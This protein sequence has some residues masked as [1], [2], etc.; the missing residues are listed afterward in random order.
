M[1]K[2]RTIHDRHDPERRVAANE[3][4]QILEVV[5]RETRSLE[6]LFTASY[7]AIRRALRHALTPGVVLVSVDGPTGAVGYVS[8]AA[9]RDRL[10][11]AIVGRHGQAD[12]RLPLDPQV[13]LRHLAV[14]LPPGGRPHTLLLD[15]NT[16]Q[17][18]EDER[19]VRQQAVLADGPVFFRL[20]RYAVFLL[21][22]EQ[23]RRMPAD[24]RE[25]WSRI[26]P[27]VYLDHTP[28][29][30]LGGPGSSGAEDD[31]SPCVTHVSSIRAPRPV[32]RSLLES[33]EQPLGELVVLARGSGREVVR[34]GATAAARGVL[35]GRYE[36]C[37]TSIIGRG[38]G[39]QSTVSRVHLLVIQQGGALCPARALGP[40]SGRGSP[41]RALYAIDTASTNGTFIGEEEV[42][43]VRLE[44]GVGLTL[45]AQEAWVQWRVLN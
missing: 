25:A 4:T 1:L 6:D 8:L 11:A 2:T 7:P 22:S 31:S 15:L 5:H 40:H 44:P 24:A 9:G 12:L 20:G 32:Q 17:G 23:G 38:D 10:A 37:A 26:P 41:P 13:A 19:G 3:G 28:R 33:G 16:G 21:A 18:F 45:G 43:V 34:L 29:P 39:A 30:E 36:R 42:R 27:R 14:L 35:V